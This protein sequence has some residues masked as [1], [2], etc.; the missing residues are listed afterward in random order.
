M[1]NA[2]KRRAVTKLLED[3]EWSQWSNNKIARTCHVAPTFVSN[4]RKSLSTVDSEH[5]QERTYTNKH[6]DVAVMNTANIGKRATEEVETVNPRIPLNSVCSQ[7][8]TSTI[9][10]LNK[11]LAALIQELEFKD[12][13]IADL[14][15]QL[16][17]IRQDES[18]P[19]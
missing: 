12:E 19:F 15:K 9:A 3:P 18:L 8:C 14:E 6:G 17:K 10:E 7:N 1:T 4:L 2:D 5:S 11:R 13:L 16:A